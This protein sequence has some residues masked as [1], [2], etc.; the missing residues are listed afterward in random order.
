M[1]LI[2]SLWFIYKLSLIKFNSKK[3]DQKFKELYII[4]EYLIHKYIYFD[5]KILIVSDVIRIDIFDN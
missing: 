1:V 2:Q 4:E 5:N 3:K